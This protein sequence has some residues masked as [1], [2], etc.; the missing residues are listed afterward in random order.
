MKKII[1]KIIKSFYSMRTGIILLIIIALTSI[2]GTLI[3]QGNDPRFYLEAY[4]SFG[5]IIILCDF[6]KVYSSWWY[7][8]LTLLLLVNLLFCSINRFKIIFEKSFKEPDIKE[9]LKNYQDFK[10]IKKDSNIFEILKIKNPKETE[11][12]GKKVYYK[13]DGKIGHLGSWLTHLSIIVII[14]AFAF[15]RY[16]GFDEFV[17]GVP[18]T[19]LELQNSDKKIKINQYDVLFREDYTVDQYITSLEVLDKDNK[20]LGEGL[21]MVNKPFRFDGFN[22]YQNSTGWAYEAKLFKDKKFFEEKLM[23]KGDFF[24]ADNKKIALQFVDFYPDFD[25]TSPMKPRTKSPFLHHPVALYALFYDGERVDMGLN[26][27]G[28]P[29]EWEEYSFVIDNP[30]MFT[31]LQVAHDPG[32]NFA[33]I[34]AGLLMIG[35]FLS[36]YI[37]PRDF[38]LV[39]EDD[40]SYLFVKYG[41]KDKISKEKLEK[42]IGEEKYD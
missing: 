14:L 31:L 32:K 25:E 28:E 33:L 39:E 16:K 38:I 6:D 3:P 42:I 10:K 18:G 23:Y 26:H 5:K 29:I 1:K 27:P 30:Q 34:G 4:P 36:F 15:G 17:H 9:R 41:K 13:F 40:F 7:I 24:I 8:L 35:L 19:V 22:I 20:K 12:D 2:I 37:N 11:I 21:T